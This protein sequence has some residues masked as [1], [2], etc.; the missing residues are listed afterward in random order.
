MFLSSSATL[1]GPPCTCPPLLRPALR[2]CKAFFSCSLR[3]V[4]VGRLLKSPVT[5]SSLKGP[6]SKTAVSCETVFEARTRSAGSLR[7]T[8]YVLYGLRSF[9]RAAARHKPR[10]WEN[11]NDQA[12]LIQLPNTWTRAAHHHHRTG[13]LRPTSGLSA[14]VRGAVHCCCR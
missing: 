13:P 2:M 10:R 9:R 8:L 14:C 1:S 5:S 12:R 4:R 3:S 11:R 6:T 7:P